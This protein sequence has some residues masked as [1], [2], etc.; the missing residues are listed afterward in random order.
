MIKLILQILTLKITAYSLMP[1]TDYFG[2]DLFNVKDIN[3]T[4][5]CLA[6]CEKVVGCKLAT[7]CNSDSTCYIKNIKT[8]PSTKYNCT[9]IDMYPIMNTTN[10]PEVTIVV[11]RT[12]ST[13]TELPKSTI[14]SGAAIT[15]FATFSTIALVLHHW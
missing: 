4:S 7:W 11:P 12:P 10:I 5:N 6:L 14:S 2:G 9:T 15:E 8:S 3:S 13:S 1:E